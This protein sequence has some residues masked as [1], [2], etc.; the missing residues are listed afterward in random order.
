[1]N[2]YKSQVQVTILPED[3]FKELI[4]KIKEKDIDLG[5][6][7]ETSV[8]FVSFEDGLLKWESCPDENCKELFK[9]FFSPVIRPLINEIFGIG[10]KIEPIRCEKKN[11]N[12]KKNIN[13]KIKTESI[14]SDKSEDVIKKV[15]EIFGSGVLIE[16]I[17]QK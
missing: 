9:R 15:R 12:I 10:T 1:L 16:K 3:R 17:I 14:L 8:K 13:K 7:F 6:C 2:T 4:K 5:V 11:E